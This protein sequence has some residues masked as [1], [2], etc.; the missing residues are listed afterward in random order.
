ME[1]PHIELHEMA[2]EAA[3]AYADGNI[4]RAEEALAKMDLC[5]AKVVAALEALKKD[6]M[7]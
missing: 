7:E 4:S 5:S 1:Q 6:L 3:L 2:K